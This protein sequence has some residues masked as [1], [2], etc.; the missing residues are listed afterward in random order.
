MRKINKLDE[1]LCKR[2][3]DFFN[4]FE[5]VFARLIGYKRWIIDVD[6][7]SEGQRQ[8][9]YDKKDALLY[10][11]RYKGSNYWVTL[12]DKTKKHKGNI[13]GSILINDPENPVKMGPPLE[14]TEYQK[15][16]SKSE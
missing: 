10:A 13:K 16:R 3:D 12:V 5:P 8:E 15:K 14:E 7:R 6:G 2:I 4:W 1:F 9:F 11:N